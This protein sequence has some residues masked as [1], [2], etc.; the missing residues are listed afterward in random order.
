MK[1]VIAQKYPAAVAG[2]TVTL[3]KSEHR[4]YPDGGQQRDFI[5]VEDCVDVILWLLAR[6]T[7]SGLFNL[8]SGRARSFED[9]ALALFAALGREPRIA[10]VDMPEI[11]QGRYQYFTEARME[12]LRDRGYTHPSPISKTALPAMFKAISRAQIPTAEF[13]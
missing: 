9:L 7:V 11:L 2:G 5:F 3:F 6:P 4:D 12:R 1:S 10:Y 13:G 8:G